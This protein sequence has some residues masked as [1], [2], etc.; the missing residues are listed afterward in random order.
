METESVRQS[1]S[2]RLELDTPVGP[3]LF[4]MIFRACA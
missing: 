2:A 3:T 4:K 1:V